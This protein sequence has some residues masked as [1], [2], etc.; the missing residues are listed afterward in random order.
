VQEEIAREITEKLRLKL[1]RVEMSQI[2]KRF[3]QHPDAYQSYLKGRYFWN[4]RSVDSLRK[5]I[6][7]FKQ[8]IDQDPAFA[9]AYAGL[10]DSR[11]YARDR[12]QLGLPICSSLVL[13]TSDRNGTLR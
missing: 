8:A 13:G 5:G 11:A 9:S 7:Y 2:A 6:E 1:T 10:S 4:K 3:T 12:A